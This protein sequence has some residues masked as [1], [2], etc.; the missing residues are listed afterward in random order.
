MDDDFNSAGGMGHIFDF[1]KEINLARDQGVNEDILN[2]AQ[3]LLKELTAI[4][5]LELDLPKT[6]VGEAGEY[7]DLLIQ[8]R[9]Q[10]REKKL[11]DL[12]DLIRDQLELLDV[13]LEDN[14]QGTTWHWK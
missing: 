6:G 8:I 11:W 14:S 7:I 2:P 10:L 12:S 5:G 1:V 9:E 13:V 4:L 3:D